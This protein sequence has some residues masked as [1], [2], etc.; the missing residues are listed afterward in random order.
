MSSSSSSSSSIPN[1]YTLRGSRGRGGRG[2]FRR[3]NNTSSG[4]TPPVINRDLPIQQTD[5]D[6]S[7]ARMSAVQMGYLEDEFAG[8]FLS[9][10]KSGAGERRMPIINRGTYVRTTSLDHLISLF[11]TPNPQTPKQILSLGAG[12]DTRFFR[13]LSRSQPQPQPLTYHE[14]DF[15]PLTRQKI[16]SISQNER[17]LGMIRRHAEAR[18]GG[19]GEVEIDLERGSLYSPGYNIHPVDL[20][21]LLAPQAQAQAQAQPQLKNLDL[22]T[23]TLVLSECLL[24]YLPSPSALLAHLTTSL[25]PPQTPLSVV[26][27]E[28]LAPPTSFSRTMTANLSL[29]GIALS[30]LPSLGAQVQRLGGAGLGTGAGAGDVEFLWE[31]WVAGAEKERVGGLEMWD[32]IEE[33]GLIGR[34][35]CVV[36]GWRKGDAGEDPFGAWREVPSQESV[37]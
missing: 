24:C 23:P 2:A 11:L 9:A 14:L 4:Q 34:H 12:S 27:Y 1:L 25:F 30:L 37:G 10:G 28:P 22:Q 15:P 32:E 6:A 21:T 13:I 16:H 18:G 8:C 33:W 17:L 7:V 3:T 5:Q 35:Y 20:R 29:R 19:T 36:W 31:R 26:I